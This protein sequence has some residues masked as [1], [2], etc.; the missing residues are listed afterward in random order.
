MGSERGGEFLLQLWSEQVGLGVF[1]VLGL[2]LFFCAECCL[3]S[4]ES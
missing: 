4:E 1:G 2:E 3:R